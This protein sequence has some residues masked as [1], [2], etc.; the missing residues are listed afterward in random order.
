MSETAFAGK[1][2][3]SVDLLTG[4]PWKQISKFMI[5]LF[6]GNLFQ[7]LY[8]TADSI[9]VGR[10][11]G[12]TALAAV[13]VSTPLL[14]FL[15]SIFIG[16]AT[17][18]S[19]LVSQYYGARDEKA[20]RLTLHTSIMLALFVG[21]VLSIIGL[22]LS[23]PFLRLLNTPDDTFSL[24]LTYMRI[25]FTGCLGMMLYNM[26][27]GFMRGL[28]NSRT[29]LY[30]LIFTTITNIVLDLIF[31][32]PLNWGI[33]G[34]AWATIISMFL[35]AILAIITLNKFSSLTR[36][37]LNELRINWD[38]A[39]EIIRLGLPTAIQ[40]GVLSLGGVIIQGF[41]NSYG[42]AMIAGHNA[43]MRVDMFA[44]MPIMSFSMA[45]VTYTGQNVG[46]GR[47]DRVYLGTKQGV[48][49]CSSVT[50][51]LAT[52]I[53][54]FG[55]YALMLFTEDLHTI[56]N[57]LMIIRIIAPFYILMAVTQTLGG[58]MRG[59]GETI[60]PMINVL[61][62]N[63]FARVP[64]VFLLSH[65]FQRAEAIYWSQAGGLLFGVI[66]ML[67]MY[68]SGKWERTALAKIEKLR[69]GRLGQGDDEGSFDAFSGW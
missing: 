38:S 16:V 20:L 14:F 34:A 9:I 44:I 29:P 27:S 1:R 7:Q 55:E 45:M 59:S 6:I 28:G 8:N 63:I 5:P 32:I 23:A 43:A 51:F 25:I 68:K 60:S 21:I 12:H 4:T 65:F 22:L 47:M 35:S 69:Q 13:G 61:M 10:W 53:Y 57:G 54:V 24:A 67:I 66:H 3:V 62:T 40:Q 41:V 56:M 31:V 64:L 30:I 37:S 15:I 49:L 26:I 48:A 50:I 52:I 36:I 18:S 39:K 17:G 46:A 11:V 58:V 33:A 19:I 2:S 42:T